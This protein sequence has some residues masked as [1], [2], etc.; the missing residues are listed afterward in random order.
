MLRTAL[1]KVRQVRIA[2][3]YSLTR[4]PGEKVIEEHVGDASASQVKRLQRR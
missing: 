3:W 2:I 4:P 1:Q